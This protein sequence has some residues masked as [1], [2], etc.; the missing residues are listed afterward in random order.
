MKR[1]L[2]AVAATVGLAGTAFA[3]V[4]LAGAGAT[5]PAPLYTEYYMPN[6]MRANPDIRVTYAAVGSGAGIRQFT[7]RVVAFGATDAPLSDTAIADIRRATGSTPLHIPTAMG[8]VVVIYNLPQVPRETEIRLDPDTLAAI[9]LG[10]VVRWNDPRI[11][12]LNPNVRLPN[13]MISAVHR[14]DASGTTLIYT[15]YLSAISSEWRT[16]VG[17]ATSV[18]WP[19]FT[20]LGGR[21]NAGV[22]A[23]VAQTPGAIGYVEVK[24]ALENNLPIATLRNQ[25]GNWIR[26]TLEAATEAIAGVTIP[27][28]M[29]LPGHVINTTAPRGY[30]IVGMTWLLVHQEQSVT[31]RSIAEARAVQRFLRWILT[32]GQAQNE[33]ANYVRLSPDIA[34]RALAIV[35]TMTFNGQPIR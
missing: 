17:A 22:A 32:D 21:G 19:A 18:N 14:S 34:R 10:R 13:Q 1:T 2:L 31:A 26:P 4:T 25:A 33:R 24:F 5:F 23:M 11:Q 35:D 16:R 28:D 3:Q 20:T 12:A 9:K 30:P 15:S 8:S 27:A 29:R 6:F 7:D